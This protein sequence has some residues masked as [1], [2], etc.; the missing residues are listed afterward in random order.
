MGKGKNS[1]QKNGRRSPSP[2]KFI[3]KN[4]KKATQKKK[5]SSS[6]SVSPQDEYQPPKFQNYID[7]EP[8]IKT[9]KFKNLEEKYVMLAEKLAEYKHEDVLKHWETPEGFLRKNHLKYFI[10]L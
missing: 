5:H 4:K 1:N 10:Y 8:T 6:R 7:Y 2:D 9:T 3:K